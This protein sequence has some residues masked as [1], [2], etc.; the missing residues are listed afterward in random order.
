MAYKMYFS[1]IYMLMR[2]QGIGK[3]NH[4]MEAYTIL[5]ILLLSFQIIL[6]L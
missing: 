1:S 3:I 6:K 4:D 5:K 2:N